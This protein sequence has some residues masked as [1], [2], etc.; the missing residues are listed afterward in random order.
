MRCDVIAKGIIE[1][2]Q[3]LGLNL[4]L[5]V[6]LQGTEVDAAKKL[7]SESGLRMFS[8]DDLDLAATKAVQMSKIVDMGRKA[9]V[10]V[11]FEL[12]I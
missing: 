1:A 10:N 12:P 8:I 5:V 6:R 11:K 9:G 2:V 3:Q 4:P 7:I